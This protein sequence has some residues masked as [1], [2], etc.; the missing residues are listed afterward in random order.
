MSKF[1]SLIKSTGKAVKEVR[2]NLLTD[3]A[4]YNA[5]QLVRTKESELRALKMRE[6]DMTDFYPESEFSLRVTKKEFN[7]KQWFAELCNL[8]VDIANMEVE[9]DI[10]KETYEEW[11]G[12]EEEKEDAKEDK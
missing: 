5:E 10:Y 4:M 6:N 12:V 8:R 9:V 3:N 1:R 2:G 11:F 7:D